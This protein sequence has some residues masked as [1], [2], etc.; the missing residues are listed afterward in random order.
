VQFVH[1]TVNISRGKIVPY[2]SLDS[3]KV[4]LKEV[5]KH[6]FWNLLEILEDICGMSI[7]VILGP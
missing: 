7:S 1:G 6:L 5:R 3:I 4:I 2:A